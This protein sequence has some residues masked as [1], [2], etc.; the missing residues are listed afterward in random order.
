MP[1]IT[2]EL[3]LKIA[4]KLEAEIVRKGPHDIALVRHAGRLVA[5]FGIRHGSRKDAGH[6]F[7]PGAIY[8]RPHEALLLGQC[9]MSRQQWIER[10]IEKGHIA[11]SE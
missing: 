11:R 8:V 6:D 5:Q 10:M 1:I 2:K 7:I 4:E 9:P 3:A